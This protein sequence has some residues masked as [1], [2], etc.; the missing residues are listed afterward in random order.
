MGISK[1]VTG[2]LDCSIQDFVNRCEMAI[3]EEQ[4]KINPDTHL[5]AILCDAIRLVDEHLDWVKLNL[6]I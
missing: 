4:R 3:E 1:M 5:I 2:Q 6:E